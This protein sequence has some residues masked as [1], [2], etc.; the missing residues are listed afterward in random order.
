MPTTEPVR[1]G[2]SNVL[3]NWPV[4]AIRLGDVVLAG[5]ALTAVFALTDVRE[6]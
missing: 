5:T 1:R 4:M 2:A 6:P 3:A